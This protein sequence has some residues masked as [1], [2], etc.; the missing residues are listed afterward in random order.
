MSRGHTLNVSDPEC[1][2]IYGLA[3]LSRF[4]H[5]Q[6]HVTPWTVA[7]RVPL[8]MG[9]S[10]Q[11]YWSGLPFSSPGDLPD[12]GIKPTSLK[13]PALAG[14]FFT[15]S[16]TLNWEISEISS[17]SETFPCLYQV[18]SWDQGMF[19]GR[20]QHKTGSWG[21]RRG[22]QEEGKGV[23]MGRHYEKRKNEQVGV[24]KPFGD[25]SHVCRLSCLIPCD[26]GP[27]GL[28][29]LEEVLFSGYRNKEVTGRGC[30]VVCGR[31]QQVMTSG[32]A[33]PH[34]GGPEG[35]GR[36][37][38]GASYEQPWSWPSPADCRRSPRWDSSLRLSSHLSMTQDNL[39][40]SV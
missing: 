36:L 23:C 34:H 8:S 13:S 7:L 14:T 30:P 18:T 5:V 9:L 33:A 29:F 39:L 19:P 26:P 38:H 21:K 20:H 4:S 1:P 27:D 17:N 22:S 32:P 37:C 12:L 28:S 25:W 10:R 40:S 35:H 31:R 2:W 6:L 3:V 11:E 24:G 15:I 16:A